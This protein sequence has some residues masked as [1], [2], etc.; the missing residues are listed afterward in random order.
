MDQLKIEGFLIDNSKNQIKEVSP[1]KKRQLLKRTIVAII[2]ILSFLLFVISICLVFNLRRNVLQ[3][4]NEERIL[5]AQLTDEEN[6]ITETMRTI[7][8]EEKTMGILYNDNKNKEANINE[9]K[10]EKN[11]VYEEFTRAQNEYYKLVNQNGKFDFRQYGF[12]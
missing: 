5:H 2:F 8:R 9:L 4:K 7:Q 10:A 12:E 6:K 1:L 3:I 11:S